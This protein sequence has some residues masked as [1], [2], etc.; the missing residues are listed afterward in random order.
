MT[1]LV[2]GLVPVI[3]VVELPEAFGFAGNG[4]TWTP[5]DKPGHDGKRVSVALQSPIRERGGEAGA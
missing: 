5:W 3:H 2:P 4:A 1:G